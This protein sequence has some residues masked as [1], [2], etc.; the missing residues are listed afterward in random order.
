MDH[1]EPTLERDGLWKCVHCLQCVANCPKHIEPAEDIS[2]LRQMTVGAGHD[3]GVG[4]Q[5]ARAF[6]RDIEESGRL[7]EPKMALRTEGLLKT[8]GRFPF[9]L[10]MLSH[11]KLDPFAVFTSRSIEGH[12]GL[13]KA[14]DAARKG[15]QK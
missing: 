5:H 13:C 3:A 6:L 9:A 8:M 15:E 12:D 11:G 2:R 4:P 14:L 10:R 1:A 7:N